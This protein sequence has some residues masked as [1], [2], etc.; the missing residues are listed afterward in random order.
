M[1]DR[2]WSQAYFSRSLNHSSCHNLTIPPSAA[3]A[4]ILPSGLKAT[5]LTIPLPIYEGS[6][7]VETG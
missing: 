1:S 5:F 7:P 3:V 4:N 2:F 6:T